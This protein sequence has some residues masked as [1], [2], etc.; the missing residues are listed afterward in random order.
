MSMEHGVVEGLDVLR[1]I[2]FKNVKHFWPSKSKFKMYK[3]RII[4]ALV[5]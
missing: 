3:L 4:M 5:R 2:I 1:P